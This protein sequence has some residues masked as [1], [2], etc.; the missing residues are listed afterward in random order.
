M[1]TFI[2]DLP[3]DV[4]GFVCENEDGDY[5]ILLNARHTWEKNRETMLHEMEHIKN[6]DTREGITVGEVEYMRHGRG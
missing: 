5:T 3:A 1:R 6:G 2:A 4:C